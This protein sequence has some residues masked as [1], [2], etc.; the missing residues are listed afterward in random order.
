MK[1]NDMAEKHENLTII[2]NDLDGNTALKVNITSIG[3]FYLAAGEERDIELTPG[4]TLT[5]SA[6][7]AYPKDEEET[8]TVAAQAPA[9]E[10]APTEQAPAP[11]TEPTPAAGEGQTDESGNPVEPTPAA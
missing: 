5:I 1:D 9:T 11:A 2:N 10:P 7:K 6:H 4:N 8:Q 3:D